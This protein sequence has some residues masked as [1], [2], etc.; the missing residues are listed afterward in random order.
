MRQVHSA[1][2]AAMCFVPE[3]AW[4]HDEEVFFLPLGQLIALLA[5]GVIAW[6]ASRLL[7]VRTVIFLVAIIVTVATW[8]LPKAVEDALTGAH[9]SAGRYFTIGLAPVAIAAVLALAWRSFSHEGRP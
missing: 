8:T 5:T 1:I 4:A 2:C 9:A 7:A 6:R 3:L